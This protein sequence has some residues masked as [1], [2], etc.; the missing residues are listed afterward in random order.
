MGDSLQSDKYEV[1][2]D[3]HMDMVLYKDNYIEVVVFRKEEELRVLS[4]RKDKKDLQ[5]S[6][7]N[8]VHIVL[9]GSTLGIYVFHTVVFFHK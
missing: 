4:F 2:E 3:A 7:L 8:I 9:C 1:E 5:G 6:L